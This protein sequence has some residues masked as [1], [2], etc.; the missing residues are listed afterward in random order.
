MK[1]GCFIK[2]IVVLTII[3]AVIV[4]I[5][6]NKLDEFIIHP[7]KK[8]IAELFVKGID[9]EITFLKENSEKDSL[10]ILFKDL[11]DNKILTMK[12][13]S[14][15]MFDPLKDSLDVFSSDSIIDKTELE[16][17]KKLFQDINYEGSKKN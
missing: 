8:A 17:L 14:N 2:T 5:I 4:W 12:N 10:K 7:G 11:M 6:Q 16:K 1:P 3:T 15:K 9:K 13:F